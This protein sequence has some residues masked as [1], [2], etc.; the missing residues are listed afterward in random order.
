MSIVKQWFEEVLSSPFMSISS[1]SSYIIYKGFKISKIEDEYKI[2]DVRFSDFYTPV[3][4]AELNTF[5]KIGF[6]RGADWIA[7][8]RNLRRV[9]IYTRLI[10]RLYVEKK[11]YSSKLRPL[12]TRAFY[13]KKLRNCQENI[14]KTIDLL[15]LYKSRVNQYID[16]YNLQK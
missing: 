4:E 11:E 12:K 15:F 9:K 5:K 3:K 1:K 16:K 10:E 13:K 6:I 2:E 8:K 14:H 7:H